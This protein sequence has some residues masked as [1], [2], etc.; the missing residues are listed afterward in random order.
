MSVYFTEI[1][2][3][4]MNNAKICERKYKNDNYKYGNKNPK[5]EE[6]KEF[7]KKSPTGLSILLNAKSYET[8]VY[9]NK[10]FHLLFLYKN[11]ILYKNEKKNFVDF[12]EKHCYEI[13]SNNVVKKSERLTL[14]S[15]SLYYLK[16]LASQNLNDIKC[17]YFFDFIPSFISDT[18]D[19]NS[20]Y[21]TEPLNKDNTHNYFHKENFQ[22]YEKYYD[23]IMKNI[24][25]YELGKSNSKYVEENLKEASWQKIFNGDFETNLSMMKTMLGC[26]LIVILQIII[27][28]KEVD[29]S[30]EAEI[31]EVLDANMYYLE[32]SKMTLNECVEHSI[33]FY[34]L[35]FHPLLFD[36]IL[37]GGPKGDIEDE[38]LLDRYDVDEAELSRDVI[39]FDKNIENEVIIKDDCIINSLKQDE[40]KK[41]NIDNDTICHM[42]ENID[43]SCIKNILGKE[44]AILMHNVD[45]C[46]DL[47]NI[48]YMH[49]EKMELSLKN[50]PIL[51]FQEVNAMNIQDTFNVNNFF[52][53]KCHVINGEKFFTDKHMYNV[54]CD[55]AIRYGKS[56]G[57][58]YK[59]YEKEM[60]DSN[61]LIEKHKKFDEKLVKFYDLMENI[62]LRK[63]STSLLSEFKKY[64]DELQF[65]K[66]DEEKYVNLCNKMK[67]L[68]RIIDKVERSNND[69]NYKLKLL[70]RLLVHNFRDI[71]KSVTGIY[72]GNINFDEKEKRR[73]E[74]DI[75]NIK[76][77]KVLDDIYGHPIVKFKKIKIDR[78]HV[79]KGSE[80]IREDDKIVVD[81]VRI[82]IHRMKDIDHKSEISNIKQIRDFYGIGLDNNKRPAESATSARQAK[83]ARLGTKDNKRPATKDNNK[84]GN[85][86][87]RRGGNSSMGVVPYYYIYIDERLNIEN[88]KKMLDV[89]DK[90]KKLMTI[91][92]ET[93]YNPMHEADES[94]KN[95]C[96]GVIDVVG[97]NKNHV[98]L[99]LRG[100]NDDT[101]NTCIVNI[102]LESGGQLKE[103]NYAVMELRKLFN[104][105][106]KKEEKWFDD[107]ENVIIMGDFNLGSNV[108]TEICYKEMKKMKRP[109][110]YC[111]VMFDRLRTHT[112]KQEKELEKI[113]DFE[114]KIDEIKS[115]LKGENT[116]QNIKS[117]LEQDQNNKDLKIWFESIVKLFNQKKLDESNILYLHKK[118]G[119]LFKKTDT[120]DKLKK[121]CIDNAIILSKTKLKNSSIGVGL[122]R[123]NIYEEVYDKI[124]NIHSYIDDILKI[125]KKELKIRI[126]EYLE[127]QNIKSNSVK[128]NINKMNSLFFSDHSPII[129]SGLEFE[130]S[131]ENI[132]SDSKSQKES[133]NIS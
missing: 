123:S 97:D 42:S 67:D 64:S 80:K 43:S 13:K 110:R 101:K 113:E 105:I 25:L 92:P 3:E 35:Y 48:L 52:Y 102:H 20:I 32:K 21:A 66:D 114:K 116:I 54:Y 70:K 121:G 73:S 24:Q 85:K 36:D 2:P 130:N 79:M 88:S 83:A 59:D 68:K 30:E 72:Y 91:F 29:K 11:E 109:R 41:I 61:K 22:G 82:M 69:N 56:E 5:Q 10:N 18:L 112:L 129:I 78:K 65:E 133:F 81:D 4:D 1:M 15:E 86:R 50:K 127:I 58:E 95:I 90:K 71:A 8:G 47:E 107:I 60:S 44:H 126:E 87:M 63:R 28:L 37:K 27:S 132:R 34:K 14:N 12:I 46:F 31:M 26:N 57:D 62:Y 75:K 131:S 106:M 128:G 89:P 118:F 17:I 23:I 51:L 74:E 124:T 119:K 108:I 100:N 45:N 120:V 96:I 117:V 55:N 99:A 76:I 84:N 53:R 122:R 49:N 77:R 7:L 94:K 98:F 9:G 16:T 111:K 39:C 33:C 93:F 6:R 19:S 40:N 115:K 103:Q 104:M 125:T 38:I